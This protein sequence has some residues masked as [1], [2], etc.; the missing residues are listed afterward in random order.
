MDAIICEAGPAYCS[1]ARL[2]REVCTRSKQLPV[3]L[4]VEPESEDYVFEDLALSSCH[5]VRSGA[6]LEGFHRLLTEVLGRTRR[7]K[8]A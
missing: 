2:I 7:I 3:F 1:S 6:P 5:V 8:A 4:F